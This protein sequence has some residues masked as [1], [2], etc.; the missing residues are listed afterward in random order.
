MIKVLLKTFP[1]IKTQYSTEPPGLNYHRRLIHYLFT[2]SQ[3]IT[4]VIT[5]SLIFTLGFIS[6]I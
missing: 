3:S 2:E 5:A 4:D 1:Q 6:H